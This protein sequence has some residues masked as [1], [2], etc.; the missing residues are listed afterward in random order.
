MSNIDTVNQL[1]TAINFDRFY[2]IEALHAPN[3]VFHSFRGPTLRDSVSVSDWHR[4]FLRD[5]ADCNYTDLEYI[6][7]GP[8]VAVRATIEAKGYDWR[9]F[10]QRVVEVFTVQEKLVT[11]RRMYGMLRDLELDKP[12]Q[13]SMDAALEVPGGDL[14]ETE[15]LVRAAL[16]ATDAEAAAEVFDPKA[17][18]I[19]SVYGIAVGPE[20][21]LAL[22]SA[23]PRPAF[24]VERVTHGYPG[25]HDALVE[26]AIDPA[27][28]R[29]ADWYRIVD[30][31]IRVIERYWM[32]REIGVNPYVNYA[33]DRHQRQVIM[34]I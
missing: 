27:R 10:T 20:N 4:A 13:Q 6:A 21:I 17:V 31:K 26:R 34:P 12:A 2:E 8:H 5:Y 19:D 30:G 9:A 11:E 14:S 15:K 3:V 18:L 24:G 33:R 29:S 22:T 28:P 32:L 25:E 1:L 23:T 7:D 16:D